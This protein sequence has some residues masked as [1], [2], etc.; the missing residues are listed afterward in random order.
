MGI[1]KSFMTRSNSSK[2]GVKLVSLND[3]DAL[4]ISGY[5]PLAQQPEV[6]IAVDKIAKLISTMTIHLMQNKENGDVR[7]HNS[8]SRKIDINPWSGSTR[9]NFMYNIVSNMILE[10]NSFV[11][12]V[13]KN[14]LIQ[15]LVPLEPSLVTFDESSSTKT[16]GYYIIYQGQAYRNDEVLHF[17]INPD[18]N[19]PYKGR[20]YKAPLR[21]ILE[22]LNQAQAT[23]KGFLSSK[24]KPSIIISVDALTGELASKEGREKILEKYIESEGQGQPWVIPGGAMKV[25]DVKP[26]SLKDLAINEGVEIDKKTVASMFGI[27]S[28]ILGIGEFNK[29]EY[30]S[31]ID[32]TILPIA[33]VIEQ[34]L[35][36]KLLISNEMYFRFNPR[37]LYAYSTTDLARMGSELYTRGIMTGNEVRDLIGFGPLDQLDELIILENYIPL[38]E[39]GNQKKLGGDNSEKEADN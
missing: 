22:N 27:P 11:Y 17:L 28:F 15:D 3:Y 10:G 19:K 26:L 33:R 2:N 16:N 12:P 9:S 18:P 7:V 24:W 38:E 30:N 14:G 13:I 34:E 35:T 25:H 1:F 5:T 32:S 39:T 6:K 23:K 8:L 29:D 4:C 31:F 37:S 21:P 36:K 20:S